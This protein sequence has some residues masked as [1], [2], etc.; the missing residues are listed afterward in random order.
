MEKEFVPYELALKVKA[1]GFNEPC[2]GMYQKNK[3]IWYCDKNNW[4][5]NFEVNP[6]VETLNLHIK[7]Y[8]KNVSL[9]NGIY[10]LHSCANFT[11]PTF[12]Q[13]FKWFREKHDLYFNIH[14]L[15]YKIDTKEEFLL[16][17]DGPSIS[18]YYKTYEEAEFACLIKLIE[19]VESKLK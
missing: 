11:A 4:I 7:K 3:K 6:D 17:I 5:T 16:T 12:S 19:I 18:S 2:F 15:P 9:I 1:L 8:S 10:F 13:A 14:R